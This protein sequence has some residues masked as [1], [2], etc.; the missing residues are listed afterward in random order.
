MP[1]WPW[2]AWS[3][4]ARLFQS[5]W[6]CCTPTH[7]METWVLWDQGEHAR[8]DHSM[9]DKMFA[10]SNCW[11]GE[12]RRSPCE[13]GSSSGNNFEAA[14]VHTL[15]QWYHREHQLHCEVFAD[16]CLTYRHIQCQQDVTL[17][18]GDLDQLCSWARR[19]KMSFNS[20]A[21]SSPSPGRNILSFPPTECWAS[22]SSTTTTIHTWEWKSWKTW[23]AGSTS[24]TPWQRAIAP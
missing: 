21:Q 7:F 17:L 11:R 13:I 5:V 9:A 12:F 22:L 1:E 24:R 20:N 3:L 19:W 8:V 10:E 2:S 16:D 14:D 6:H 15:H 23:T 18:Q 4:G